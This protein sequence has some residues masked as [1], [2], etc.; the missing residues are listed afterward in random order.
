MSAASSNREDKTHRQPLWKD[1]LKFN[2]NK[3]T[4]AVILVLVGITG[5]IVPVIPGLLLI[6]L[7]IALFKKGWM[8]KIRTRFGLRKTV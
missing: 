6:L 7:A 2:K 1:I 8:E 4:L 5:I 3:A